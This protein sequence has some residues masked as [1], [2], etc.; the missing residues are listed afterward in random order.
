MRQLVLT[1]EW[2]HNT[3]LLKCVGD[4][5]SVARQLCKVMLGQRRIDTGTCRSTHTH[6]PASSLWMN[7]DECGAVEDW[8][9]Q[10]G[11]TPSN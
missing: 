1:A 9:I 3:L 4:D 8:R 7:S 10:S 2:C 11:G 6:W 5:F